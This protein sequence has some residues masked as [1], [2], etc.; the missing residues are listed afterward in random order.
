MNGSA[1]PTSGL[2]SNL[3]R[4]V[5]ADVGR[6]ADRHVTITNRCDGDGLPNFGSSDYGGFTSI[7]MPGSRYFPIAVRRLAGDFN[8]DGKLDVAWAD[9]N[10]ETVN[11]SLAME[12]GG[13]QAPDS[14]FPRNPVFPTRAAR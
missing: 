14:L 2:T 8:G 13:F 9:A 6:K 5:G 12:K 4:H 1:P 7:A 11:I 3:A 10:S